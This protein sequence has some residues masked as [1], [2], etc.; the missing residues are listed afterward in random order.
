MSGSS[1]F[2][3]AVLILPLLPV[4]PAA[5]QSLEDFPEGNGK[6]FVQ[7]I[8]MQRHDLAFLLRQRRTEDDWKKTVTR[9]SQKGLGGPIGNYNVVAACMFKNFGREE[10]TS[11]INMNKASL[12]EIMAKTGLTKEEAAALLG[13][14]SRNGD[15]REW[16][17]PA[18]D[19]WS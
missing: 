16:G 5:A 7:Q 4:A 8:C 18:G 6:Q 3:A 19:L 13:Y 17:R 9:M 10:D 14:R 11:K 15:F 2:I 1:F 12:E